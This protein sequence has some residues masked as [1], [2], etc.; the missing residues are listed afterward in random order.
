MRTSALFVFL[1]FLFSAF[2]SGCQSNYHSDGSYLYVH[3]G[4]TLYSLA[5]KNN[6]SMRAIIEEN[7]LKPPYGLQVGQKLRIPQPKTHVVKKKETLYSISQK[8]NMSV[9]SLSKLNKLKSPYTLRVGQKLLISP[10]IKVSQN[11]KINRKGEEYYQKNTPTSSKIKQTPQKTPKATP[12]KGVKVPWHQSKKKFSWPVKGKITS[13]FGANAKGQHNDGINIQAP[14]GTTVRAADDGTVGYAGNE[15]KGYGN[16]ILIRHNNGWITAYA[17]N[18][19]LLVKKGAKVKK[20]EKIAT[21]G[22]TGNVKSPQLHFE[23]R[24]KTKVVNPKNY[25]Q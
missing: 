11:T 17:H 3:K 13:G 14:Q 5:R 23:I 8:Y 22:K 24:Y 16:L 10:E 21:V 18:Q 20:G 7:N 19:K 4:D 9:N 15:L 25:L 12:R 2:L 6:L 1:I